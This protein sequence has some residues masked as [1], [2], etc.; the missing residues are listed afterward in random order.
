MEK[1]SIDLWIKLCENNNI[2]LDIGANTGLYSLIAQSINNNA[3]IYAF[4]PIQRVYNKLN[5]NIR[6]NSYHIKAF[7]LAISN[8]TE[9][10]RIFDTNSEHEYA[11]TL[12]D[13][14][15]NYSNSYFVKAI[16]LD[17]FIEQNN[18]RKIDLIKIDVEAYEDKVLDGYKKYFALHSPIILLEVLYDEIGENIQSFIEASLIKYDY[19][20]IDEEIG[21]VKVQNIKRLSDK[22]FNY[23]LVPVSK[24][25]GNN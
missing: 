1:T 18:I 6:L 16:S 25:K 17:D 15:T 4:E 5:Y 24:Y 21:L 7:N 9:I 20:F 11:A 19:Y 8:K 14:G 10:V 13:N 3:S 2:I 23:L 12:L 22:Y